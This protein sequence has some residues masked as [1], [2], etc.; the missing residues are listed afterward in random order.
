MSTAELIARAEEHA[1][2]HHES[3][4]IIGALTAEIRYRNRLIA[5]I[6]RGRSR[7]RW[8]VR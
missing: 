1:S 2:T 7:R 4:E 5:E 8:W 6:A 3:A